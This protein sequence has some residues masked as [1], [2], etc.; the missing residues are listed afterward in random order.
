MARGYSVG[1]LE[2]YT[3]DMTG[4]PPEALDDGHVLQCVSNIYTP[5]LQSLPSMVLQ[6]FESFG[7]LF[8]VAG[9]AYSYYNDKFLG[10]FLTESI[11]K[12]LLLVNSH[13]SSHA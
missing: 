8:G 9:S 10:S 4:G 5:S 11:H 12:S 1:S 3:T 7:V 13:K 6:H 2:A